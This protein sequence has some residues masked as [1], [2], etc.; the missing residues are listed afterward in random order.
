MKYFIL[1]FIILFCSG[2]ISVKLGKEEVKVYDQYPIYPVQDKP[3]L[4]NISGD[5]MKPYS[6]VVENVSEMI[7][8]GI[9]TPDELALYDLL[10]EEANKNSYNGRLLIIDNYDKLIRWGRVNQ[11]TIESYNKYA[12]DKNERLKIDNKK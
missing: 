12:S 4:N 1:L 10:V 2:C 5:L 9:I 8:D 6:K 3:F 11:A 7:K